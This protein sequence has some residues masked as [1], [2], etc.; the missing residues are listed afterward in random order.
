MPSSAADDLADL[1][2][3]LLFDDAVYRR[4][5]LGL[6]VEQTEDE[7]DERIAIEAR[8]SGIEDPYRCFTP[9]LHDLSTAISTLTVS[10]AYRSSMSIHS[11]ESHSTGFTSDPSRT[12]KDQH[13]DS[14]SASRSHQLPRTSLSLENYDSLLERFRPSMRH[15]R[16]SSTASTAG[17][18]SLFSTS[19]KPGAS[20]KRKRGPSLLSM[21]RR[22]PHN[23]TS[24][25]RHGHHVNPFTP[26]LECG[27]TLTKYATRIHV[28]EAIESGGR[29]LPNCCG[30]PLPRFVLEAV[31]TKEEMDDFL[32]LFTQY[33]DLEYATGVRYSHDGVIEISPPAGCQSLCDVAP[34]LACASAETTLECDE[35]LKAAMADEAFRALHAQREEQFQRIVEFESKQRQAISA[36]HE[37]VRRRLSS[38][39]ARNKAERAKEHAQA[40][41]QLEEAQVA[42][43][44]D[45]RKAHVQERQN[46]ATALKHMEAYCNGLTTSGMESKH[47][48]SEDDKK[49]LKRQH[50]LQDNLPH[51]HDSAINVLRAKQEKDVKVRMHKQN[52][53]LVQ[54]D[55]EFE[56]E[57]RLLEM[58]FLKESS[59]LEALMESRRRRAVARWTLRT[60]TWRKDFENQHDTIL[61]GRLPHLDW[62]DPPQEPKLA[63]AS[64]MLIKFFQLEP[65]PMIST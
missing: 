2:S 23:C 44:L 10:S 62:P 26:R 56:K 9:E 63:D 53:E 28:Q 41:E 54:M 45:L 52:A 48:V 21:F 19:K 3:S 57:N 60:E 14:P 35:Q 5:A 24:R 20:V 42:A 17:S 12:S 51:K 61:P 6:P 1:S 46:V 64:S 43:E 25:V 8:E 58:H 50:A 37:K 55:H 22:E 39:V 49:K 13:L 36:Y 11:R 29:L 30:R 18:A 15:S 33:P 31:M 7:L 16:S 47:T 40:L 4:E 34:E 59:R 32:A 38:Q 27:H 65:C